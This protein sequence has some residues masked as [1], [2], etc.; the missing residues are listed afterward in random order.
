VIILAKIV[1]YQHLP[2]I[3][4]FMRAGPVY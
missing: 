1:R 4:F 2:S 3:V